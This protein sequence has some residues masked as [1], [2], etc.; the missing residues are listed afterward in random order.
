M[1]RQLPNANLTLLCHNRGNVSIQL[2]T[3][4]HATRTVVS[5]QLING[6]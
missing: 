3:F 6:R 5:R 1:S 2:K 4:G